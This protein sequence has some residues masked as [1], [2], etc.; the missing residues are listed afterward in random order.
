MVVVLKKSSENSEGEKIIKY[1]SYPKTYY[2]LLSISFV[3]VITKK[4]IEFHMAGYGLMG[5]DW[6]SFL[7]RYFECQ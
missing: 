3:K 7:S 4:T 6:L 1:N 5:S 2:L